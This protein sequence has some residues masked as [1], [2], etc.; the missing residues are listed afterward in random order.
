MK[1]EIMM[2]KQ[3]TIKL[4]SLSKINKYIVM[5]KDNVLWNF[6][7]IEK[8]NFDHNLFNKFVEKNLWTLQGFHTH[9]SIAR[10]KDW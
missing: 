1:K 10:Y 2:K 6:T 7:L 8:L 3:I 4:L 9:L 5:W